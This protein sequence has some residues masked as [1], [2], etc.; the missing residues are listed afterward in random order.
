MTVHEWLTELR[1]TERLREFLWEPL[2]VAALNEPTAEASAEAFAEVLR[3]MFSDGPTNAAIVMP[4][5]PLDRMYAEPA[6]AF[7]EARGGEVRTSAL[8]K[9]IVESGRVRGVRVGSETVSA[10]AVIA[11]APWNS[12]ATLFDGPLPPEIGEVAAVASRLRSRPI[13]T[14]NLW[15]DRPII[16]EPFV[17]LPGCTIQWVFDKGGGPESHLSLTVSGAS[18]LVDRG[19]EEILAIA[20]ADVEARLP[21]S[22]TATRVRGTVVRERHATFSTLNPGLKR[23][24]TTTGVEGLFLAGDWIDT[25][26]PGTIEG[27]VR[28]GRLAADTVLAGG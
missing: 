14:V 25:G 21:R 22:R 5:V 11:T 3:L 4:A 9:V 8:A 23:P 12:F 1:Q 19:S 6:R 26:L 15:Y 7:I 28:S 27:A 10:D 17:G 20:V 18:Q 2:A 16:D 24:P 13:V